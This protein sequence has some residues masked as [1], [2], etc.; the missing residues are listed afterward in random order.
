MWNERYN[1]PGFAFGTEPND[2]LRAVAEKI[3]AGGDVLCI[4]E[5]EGRNAVF[6]AE[7]G[8][9]VTAMDISEVG[10]RKAS[11]LATDRGVTIKTQVADLADY[12]FGENEWDAIVSIWA[13]TPTPVRQYIHNQMATALKPSGVFILEAYTFEQTTMSGVGGPPAS[14]KDNFMSLKK[15]RAELN[16]LTEVVGVEKQRT[17]SEG[18][19]HQGL[20]AVVQFVGRNSN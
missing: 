13:H 16:D 5:G 10:L 11:Q 3:P 17:V 4:A 9:D 6:L 18:K 7:Q 20:S 2:F 19:R 15:L 1:E 8:Y 14:K 12:S